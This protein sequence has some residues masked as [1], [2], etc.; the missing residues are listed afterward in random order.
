MDLSRRPMVIPIVWILFSANLLLL[1]DEQCCG[2][3]DSQSPCAGSCY[4][5][6]VFAKQA[7]DWGKQQPV[8]SLVF[9]FEI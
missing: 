6:V 1:S 2:R 5:M 7:S 3:D 4:K 8:V 9:G